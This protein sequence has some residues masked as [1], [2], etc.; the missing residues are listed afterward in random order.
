MI[1]LP[2]QKFAAGCERVCA[3]CPQEQ[4]TE[5]R[6]LS[7]ADGRTCETSPSDRE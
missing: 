7:E 5:A 6:T 4:E 3:Q 2:F 1:G